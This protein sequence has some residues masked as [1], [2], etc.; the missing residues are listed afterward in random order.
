MNPLL[1]AALSFFMSIAVGSF[2]CAVFAQAPARAE[3]YKSPPPHL[4]A[5]LWMQTSAEYQAICRQTFNT[6]LQNA[7]RVDR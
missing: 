3:E 4:H 2:P 1:K 6:A 7:A 5:N